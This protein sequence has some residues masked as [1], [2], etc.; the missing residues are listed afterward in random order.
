VTA[1]G[2]AAAFGR[3]SGQTSTVLRYVRQ[4]AFESQQ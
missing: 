3:G 4:A 2:R 1:A